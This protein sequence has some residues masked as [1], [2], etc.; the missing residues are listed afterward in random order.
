MRALTFYKLPPDEMRETFVLSVVM[1]THNRTIVLFGQRRLFASRH[2][3]CPIVSS[4][5]DYGLPDPI[6][7]TSSVTLMSVTAIIGM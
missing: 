6:P 3:I 2:L 7:D 5:K 1:R 4:P